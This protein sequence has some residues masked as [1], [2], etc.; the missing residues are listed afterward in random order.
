MRWLELLASAVLEYEDRVGG[1]GGGIAPDEMVVVALSRAWRR[2]RAAWVAALRERVRRS[3]WEVRSR[4]RLARLSRLIV[5][6]EG[7]D[8]DDDEVEESLALVVEGLGDKVVLKVV[9]CEERDARVGRI[10][11]DDVDPVMERPRLIS[12]AVR[13][14]D[15]VAREVRVEEGCV[16]VEC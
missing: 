1:G 2:S 16:V 6:K 14:S 10:G 9:I 15:R 12:R 8:D 11:V 3:V 5:E 4:T 13:R 7:G